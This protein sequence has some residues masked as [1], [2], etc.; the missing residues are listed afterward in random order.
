MSTRNYRPLQMHRIPYSDLTEAQV[1]QALRPTASGP[2]S[3]SAMSNVL[4]GKKL[5]IVT[6][7]G[8]PTLEYNFR[9]GRELELAEN[10]GKAGEGRLRRDGE[11]RPRARVAHDSR[12]PARLQARG[13]SA[14]ASRDGVRSLLQRLRRRRKPRPPTQTAKR[15][16]QF[17]NGRRNREAQRKIWFGYVDGGGAAPT[18]RHAYTNRLEGKGIYW[19]QDT[20]VEILEFYLSIIYSNFIELHAASAAR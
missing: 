5:K 14:H 18:A 13:R 19:K 7:D 3:K 17:R 20:D 8:G 1:T 9:N 12:H 11:S 15:E 4:A 2:T 10:G 16:P 6:D